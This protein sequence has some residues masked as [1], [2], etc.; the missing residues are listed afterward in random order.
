MNTPIAILTMK[1][2]KRLQI[3]NIRNE[4]ETIMPDLADMRR[5]ISVF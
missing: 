2:N 5:L 3:T 1:R 4:G